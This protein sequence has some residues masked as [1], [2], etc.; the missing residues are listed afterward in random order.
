MTLLGLILIALGIFVFGA[1]AYWIITKFFS[2]P[3]RPIALTVVGVLL[4]I[5]LIYAFF[6][7]VF[8]HRVW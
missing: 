6:P 8:N 1:L 3:V 4:L 5:A 7:G 2:E